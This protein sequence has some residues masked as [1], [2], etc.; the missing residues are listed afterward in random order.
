MSALTVVGPT[1]SSSNQG[2]HY[3]LVQRLVHDFVPKFQYSTNV[4]VQLST[5][6]QFIPSGRT[7]LKCGLPPG[8]WLNDLQNSAGK[9]PNFH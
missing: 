9:K 5:F 2:S 4:Q 6:M 1:L 7:S 3:T 8:Q